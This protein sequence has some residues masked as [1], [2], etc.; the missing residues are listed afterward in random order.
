MESSRVRVSGPFQPAVAN[1]TH[2]QPVSLQPLALRGTR[3]LRP[4]VQRTHL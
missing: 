3:S 4:A 1:L 2:G